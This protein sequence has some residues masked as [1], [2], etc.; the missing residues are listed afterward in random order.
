MIVCQYGEPREN[1]IEQP[2]PTAEGGIG[3]ADTLPQMLDLA[4][5]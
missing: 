1:P 5:R 3:I 4:G 2:V